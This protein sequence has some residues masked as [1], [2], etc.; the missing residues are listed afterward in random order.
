MQVC[1][2]VSKAI[3][4]DCTWTTVHLAVAALREGHTVGFLDRTDLSVEANGELRTRFSKFN[5]PGTTAEEMVQA[6]KSRRAARVS[7][8]IDYFDSLFLRVRPF[9]DSL[10][11]LMLLAREQGVCIFNDPIGLIRTSPKSWLATLTD[12]ST[13]ETLVTQR[14]AAGELFFQQL[15]AVI[16]KPN[17][18]SGG[19]SVARVSAHDYGAFQLAFHRA[20]QHGDGSVVIQSEVGKPH[21]PEK[22]LLWLD[23]EVVGGYQRARAPGEFRH[24]L[25]QGGVPQSMNVSPL[26]RSLVAPLTPHLLTAGIRFA[27]IDLLCNHILEVNVLNPGGTFY[28]DRLNH[29]QLA[30]RIIHQLVTG[31]DPAPIPEKT[32]W[33]PHVP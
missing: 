15:G 5:D 9:P 23:G 6:L 13:P 24:N 27:G 32:K 7:R 10:K 14:I 16:V 21:E 22:R 11:T 2:L 20:A 18:G 31:A 30:Q 33:V 1:F 19:T 25:K 3:S 28:A 17:T 8:P 26:D 4:M 29:T 12:V